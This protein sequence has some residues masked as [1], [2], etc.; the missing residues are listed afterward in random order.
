MKENVLREDGKEEDVDWVERDIIL[1][2][3][4]T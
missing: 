1:R 2:Q 4:R 3:G